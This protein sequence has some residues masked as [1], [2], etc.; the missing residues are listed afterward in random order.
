[1][2]SQNRVDKLL[3][4]IAKY[5]KELEIFSSS[6]RGE[7]LVIVACEQGEEKMEP[8]GITKDFDF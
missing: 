7:G 2:P 1:M 4:N 6:G 8:I 5:I 3:F